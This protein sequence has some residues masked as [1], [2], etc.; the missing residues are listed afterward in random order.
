M[1]FDLSGRFETP[2]LHLGLSAPTYV[3]TLPNISAVG[4]STMKRIAGQTNTQISFL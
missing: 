1:T 2:V 3:P 4:Q